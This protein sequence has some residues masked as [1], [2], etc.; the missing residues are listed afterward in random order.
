MS[1]E[2]CWLQ[3]LRL[4]TQGAVVSHRSSPSLV[5]NTASTHLCPSP[6]PRHRVSLSEEA[7]AAAHCRQGPPLGLAEGAL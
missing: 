3:L 4:R 5:P 7:Q 1:L 6:Q 2:R